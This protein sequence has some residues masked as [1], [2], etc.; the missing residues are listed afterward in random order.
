[1]SDFQS[2]D[3]ISIISTRSGRFLLL[4]LMYISNRNLK[5]HPRRRIGIAPWFR[6][7]SHNDIESS[8][9]SEGTKHLRICWGLTKNS[10]WVNDG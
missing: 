8:N 9:L 4:L 2:E 1:M 7:R 10:E 6:L 3:E 5:Q